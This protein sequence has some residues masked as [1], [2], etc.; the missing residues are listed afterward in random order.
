MRKGRGLIVS[1]LILIVMALLLSGNNLMEGYH[2]KTE[3]DTVLQSLVFDEVHA[4]ETVSEE[5]ELPQQTVEE[6]IYVGKIEV[7]ALGI[8]LPVLSYYSPE[9]LMSAPAR[10]TGSPYTDDMIICA[11]NSYSHFGTLFRLHTGDTVIFTDLDGNVFTYELFETEILQ[12][13]QLDVLLDGDWDLTLFTCVLDN[14]QR[15]VF[16]F[17]KMTVNEY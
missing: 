16:R 8:E 14:S 1:G 5:T 3:S 4:E 2:Q 11:H 13:D 17:E 6:N 7:P 10:Y 9:G 15:R 12:H